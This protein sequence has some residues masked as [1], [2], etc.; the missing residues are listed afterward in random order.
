MLPSGND[1][2]VVLAENMG[3]MIKIL[4]LIPDLGDLVYQRDLF[5]K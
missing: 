2:A 5:R 4:R 1:A 3:A